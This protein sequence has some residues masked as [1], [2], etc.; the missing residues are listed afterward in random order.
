MRS[1]KPMTNGNKQ[2]AGAFDATKTGAAGR[3]P[4]GQQFLAG[5]QGGLGKQKASNLKP[6]QRC[7]QAGCG[8]CL[9][10]GAPSTSQQLTGHC[11]L[12]SHDGLPPRGAAHLSGGKGAE[13]HFS[14]TDVSCLLVLKRAMTIPGWRGPSAKHA[15][16]R[17]LMT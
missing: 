11:A 14:T 5:Q 16:R 10:S 9:N 1:R 4:R 6:E 3:W 8:Q 13:A 12:A 17:H 7:I 15:S 2:R